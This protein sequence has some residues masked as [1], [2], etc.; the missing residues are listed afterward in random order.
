MFALRAVV[1]A[2]MVTSLG[3]FTPS[4]AGAK[5]PTPLQIYRAELRVYDHDLAVINRTFATAI[6]NDKAIEAQALLKAKTPTQKFLARQTFNAARAQAALNR[7][8][9]IKNLGPV[10]QPPTSSK[11][12]VP[13]STTTTTTTVLP[14]TTR[15]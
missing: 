15:V 2:A 11:N 3:L 13:A 5:G 10:P 7:Q 8:T 1:V 14:G 9:A 4:M 6:A 12:N